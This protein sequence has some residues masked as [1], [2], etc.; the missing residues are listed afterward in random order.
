MRQVHYA[1]VILGAVMAMNAVSSGI[2]LSF[3]AYIDP[4]V[5]QYGWSRGGI[6]FAYTLKFLVAIPVVLVAGRLVER[7]GI[8]PVILVASVIATIGV[9]LTATVT[10]LWQ[11]QLYYGVISGALGTA[12]FVTVLPVTISRWFYRRLGLAL[13]LMWTSLSWGPGVM[14]PLMRWAIDTVGWRESFLVVGVLGGAV[15]IGSALLLRD[16]PQEVGL[17]PYGG[18]PPAEGGPDSAANPSPAAVLSMGGVAAMASFWGLVAVH[19]LGCIGHSVPLAHM[20]SIATFAGVPGLAAVGMLTVSSIT[21]VVSRFGM[22]LMSEVWGARWTLA[23]ALFLQTVP[24]L[25]LVGANDLWVFYAFAGVF[26]IGFGGEMVG[27]PIFNRQYY[28]YHAPLNTIYSYQMAAALVGMSL[29]GWLGGELFDLT[30]DYTWSI[31]VA[32]AA[33]FLGVA[34]ALALPSHRRS[35]SAEG[36]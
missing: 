16:R 5:E 3:A 25:M 22:S 27:F 33:G 8:R 28:G 9:L 31:L 14:G 30:G 23:L 1:W 35:R 34:A 13:G 12:I 6:S 2:R 7:W 4:L 11:F 36:V 15:M 26:G 19:T 24:M 32:T 20:V 21:S 10:Q 29:G 17:A 18:L